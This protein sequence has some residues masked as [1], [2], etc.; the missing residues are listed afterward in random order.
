MPVN[1]YT[2]S[3]E[4]QN[5]KIQFT[6]VEKDPQS[7]WNG[8]NGFILNDVKFEVIIGE[9]FYGP[10]ELASELT[11]K[12]NEEITKFL[13]E[14]AA[15][16][17]N[18]YE[19]NNFKVF[20]D[21]VSQK[22]WFGNIVDGFT[23]IFSNR[24]EYEVVCPLQPNVWDQ[25][26]KWGLPFNLG[27]EK[28][29]YDAIRQIGGLNAFWLTTDNM[30][31]KPKYT[32]DNTN[33]TGVYDVSG[34]VNYVQ[35]PLTMNIQGD[36]VIYMEVDKYN[37]YLEIEPYSRATNTL[38]NND[39]NGRVNSAFAKIPITTLPPGEHV[40]SRNGLLQNIV[41]FEPPIEKITTLKFKFR[42]H[43]GR[44]V[45][46]QQ[47]PFNFTIAFNRIQNE[48]PRQYNIRVP[49]TFNL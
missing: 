43:D 13:R 2:F 14:Y 29:N 16:L 39:Y 17:N 22:Y 11:G 31:L 9:G 27:F 26:T 5:T 35:A 18:T 12:I 24:I 4:Y 10:D 1:Y 3:N 25:Y 21:K 49:P 44:L 46:F 7:D 6:L 48:I 33:S 32:P 47:F 20:Y 37:S 30:W 36:R 45:D 15:P 42:Y 28:D 19:Y 40:D 41:T 34:V 8:D 23:L 38:Y